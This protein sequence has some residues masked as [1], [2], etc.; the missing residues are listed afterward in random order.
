MAKTHQYPSP[1]LTGNISVIERRTS[2]SPHHRQRDEYH[3]CNL[4]DNPTTLI[5][6]VYCHII[7]LS[8]WALVALEK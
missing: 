8:A 7:R 1:T 5:T 2:T 6:S 4:G 3:H